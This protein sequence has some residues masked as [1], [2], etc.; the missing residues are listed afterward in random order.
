M[1]QIFI[2]MT[3]AAALMVA[4]SAMATDMPAVGK[5]KCGACHAIDKKVV[6]P[7]WND[8]AKKYKGDANAASKIAANI[9]KGG[10]FG[11]K[12]GKMLPKGM[13]ATDAEI[14]SLSE[15][16]AGLK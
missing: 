6:G 3:V 5:A 16:I 10:E 14:K 8:V 4:G 13:G 15:F 12:M 2:N 7:A 9:T 1:K 11:W